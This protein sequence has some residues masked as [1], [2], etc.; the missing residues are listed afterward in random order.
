MAPA[1]HSRRNI[2]PTGDLMRTIWAIFAAAAAIVSV[3]PAT[4]H[5]QDWPTRPVKI[6]SPFAPGGAADTLGRLA[7]EQLSTVFNQQFFVENRAGGGGLIGAA[8]VAAAD[9]DGYTL[10]VSGIASN[11]L[12]PAFNAN[13]GYDGLRDFAHIAYLGGP[14]VVVIVHPSLGIKT[15]KE[16]VAYAK[17]SSKALD[18]ISP[19]VGTHG[20]I[21]AEELAR[22]EGF[23]LSHIPYKGAGPALMDLVAGHV[24]VGSI[25]FSSAAQMIRTGKVVA[26]AVSSEK[27][28]PHFPD[29]PTFVELGHPDLISETWFG[30]SGPARMPSDIVR[31]LNREADKFLQKPDVKKRMAVDEIE[32][33]PMT[34]AGYTKHI[35]AETARWVPLAKALAASS[36]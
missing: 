2:Q 3:S 16:L 33:R 28:L 29:I 13:P 26:L 19:G 12:S 4:A 23:K 17:G 9:P 21:F 34:P 36:H 11:V 22:Q 32:A 18:Y 31:L 30:L 7:A 20:Y 10:V 1:I 24:K 35:E 6:V 15:Y 5:A 8:A 14:P 25:T 27:R